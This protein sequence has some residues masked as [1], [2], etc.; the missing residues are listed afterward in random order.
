MDT[1]F[2]TTQNLRRF[3]EVHTGRPAKFDRPFREW[4]N[5]AR[6]KTL[7]DALKEFQNRAI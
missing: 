1:G 2:R 7:A 4:L 3:F 5:E 6:G